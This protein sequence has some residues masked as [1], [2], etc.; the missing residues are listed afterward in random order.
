MLEAALYIYFRK[1][2]G[3]KIAS[4]ALLVKDYVGGDPLLRLQISHVT[5]LAIFCRDPLHTALPIRLGSHVTISF[6]SLSFLFLPYALYFLEQCHH[7]RYYQVN[8]I[9]F[10]LTFSQKDLEASQI[11]QD[12]TRSYTRKVE[13]KDGKNQNVQDPG[14]NQRFGV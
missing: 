1:Q 8:I 7:S 13:T 2:K 4:E 5:A 9:L 6:F 3:R 11:I 10:S 14:R 12:K